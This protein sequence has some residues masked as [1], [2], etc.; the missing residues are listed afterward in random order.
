LKKVHRQSID[1][2]MSP[3][4]GLRLTTAS[5]KALLDAILIVQPQLEVVLNSLIG[6]NRTLNSPAASRWSDERDA[7]RV[8][9][10]IGGL[11]DRLL[12]QSWMEPS[13]PTMP[14]LAGL[15]DS[16]PEAALLDHDARTVPG[17]ALLP[18]FRA[19][20]HMFQGAGR[21]LEVTNVNATAVEAALG[22]DLIYY[23]HQTRSLVLVQYKKLKDGEY[24]VDS[25]FRSQLSRMLKVDSLGRDSPRSADWR[26]GARAAWFKLANAGPFVMGSSEMVQG[27]YLHAEY[28]EQLLEDD[29][30]LGEREGRILGYERVSRYLT[31]TLFISLVKDG[32]IGTQG[33]TPA[34]LRRLVRRS[35]RDSNS[36]VLAEDKSAPLQRNERRRGQVLR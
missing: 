36:L 4:G 32:W 22:T 9:L 6:I 35:L 30:T 26:L 29:C 3:G 17:L 10:R 11:D 25:R 27:Q 18:G 16:P 1:L 28:V 33:V 7:V 2:D 31:N 23:A 13:N 5:S 12:L 14:F 15:S 20:I 8:A 34:D 24:R 19:D 21:T